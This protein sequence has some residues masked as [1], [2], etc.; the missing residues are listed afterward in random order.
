MKKGQSEIDWI[1][2]TVAKFA[3]RYLGY[4]TF[5]EVDRLTIPEFLLHVEVQK[6][7]QVDLEYELHKE[8][9]L[10]FAAQATKKNGRPVY[11]EFS[12]FFDREK[13]MEQIN[14]PPMSE[15]AQRIVEYRKMK[16][17]GKNGR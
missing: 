4:T 15:R 12:K 16:K 9:W 7:K 13:V 14:R 2:E 17:E 1:Y 3:F 5:D 10:T 8:A 6:E 11:R